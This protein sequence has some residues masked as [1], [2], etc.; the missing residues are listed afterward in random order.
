MT[1]KDKI[2]LEIIDKAEKIATCVTKGNDV[3][4]RK[5]LNGVKIIEVKKAVVR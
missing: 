1:E 3:E 2:K 4:V 5:D